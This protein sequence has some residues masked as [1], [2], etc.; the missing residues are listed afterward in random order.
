MV[1]IY[2]GEIIE[3]GP[4][5]VDYADKRKR[6][7]GFLV[8][9]AISVVS[10]S[11]LVWWVG[12]NKII[13]TFKTINPGYLLAIAL[14]YGLSYSF[15]ALRF[16][17]LF[18]Y[19]TL[20]SSTSKLSLSRLFGVVCLHNL[21]NKVL[22]LRS[23]ELSYLLLMKRYMG[24][25]LSS[26]ISS[27]LIARFMDLLTV[28]LFF[29]LAGWINLSRIP[30]SL[31]WSVPLAG[32]GCLALLV[33]YLLLTRGLGQFATKKQVPSSTL[34][35]SFR[36][37][38]LQKLNSLAHDLSQL[39][40]GKHLLMG[41]L[42]SCGIWGGIYLIFFSM[43]KA[44]AVHLSLSL[45]VWAS[46]LSIL[47]Y[48]LP[49]SG[50]G[51]FGTYEAGWTLGLLVLAIPADVCVASGLAVNIVTSILAGT[52]GIIGYLILHLTKPP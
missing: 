24:V 51:G 44:F 40:L 32:F 31:H 10:L 43:L 45:L 14:W 22:P 12:A 9:I 4:S 1:E 23:G 18:D 15:R 28:A 6:F 20:Q 49:I 8:S 11:L 50:F 34:R 42:C 5:A 30:D 47:T 29:F 52:F 48:I 36:A 37:H 27:L 33:G 3:K 17:I 21:F 7:L 46:T 25:Q 2:P 38:A 16:Y 41:L 35:R 19:G 39:R 13:E 26:G